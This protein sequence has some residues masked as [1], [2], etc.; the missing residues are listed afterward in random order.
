MGI[1][2][3]IQ[4]PALNEEKTIAETIKDLPRK[5]KGVDD[6]KIL[7][8]ND[9]SDDRTIEVA[10]EAGADYIVNF[11]VRQGLARAFQAGLEACLQLGA[12]IIVNTDADNQYNGGDVEKLIQPILER[13][14][15]FVVGD[16]QRQA[17]RHFSPIKRMLQRVGSWAVRQLSGTNIPDVT[18]GFRAYSRNEN[19]RS[20]F[21]SAQNKC[22][23]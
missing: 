16:R 5:I 18:S 4:I 10:K 11:E 22:R 7:M 23:Y 1:K 17:M 3:I 8:I 9:G 15:D 14:A 20:D 12:D 6:I 13:K 21:R 2:L 19:V